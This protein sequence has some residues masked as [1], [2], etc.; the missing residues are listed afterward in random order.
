[1]HD[2][3]FIDLS[4]EARYWR[5]H[6]LTAPLLLIMLAAHLIGRFF[7]PDNNFLSGPYFLAPFGLLV[8]FHAEVGIRHLFRLCPI[9]WPK[10]G[11]RQIMTWVIAIE[12]WCGLA[13]AAF[14][15]LHLCLVGLSFTL[16]PDLHERLRGT[17]TDAAE[18]ILL[19]VLAFHVVGGIRVLIQEGLGTHRWD[20]VMARLAVVAAVVL[21]AAVWAAR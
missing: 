19:A 21:P 5:L 10:A 2:E 20:H 4:G 7:A 15:I 13:L 8:I 3:G 11:K 1:M 17:A 16:V 14:A 18:A 9:L 12:R 6:R